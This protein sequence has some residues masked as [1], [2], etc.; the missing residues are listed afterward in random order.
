MI[1]FKDIV[2]NK[3]M[4]LRK[5]RLTFGKLL[6]ISSVTVWRWET[7]RSR[8]EEKLIKFWEQKIKEL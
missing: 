8:P 3:R 5:G 2:K 4:A 7:G 1:E 6:G